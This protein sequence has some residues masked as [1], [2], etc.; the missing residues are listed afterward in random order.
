LDGKEKAGAVG[1]G[2]V[3]AARFGGCGVE[4]MDDVGMDL[5]QRNEF[6]VR[7]AEGGLETAAVFEDAFLA[8]PFGKTEIENFFAVQKA[9]AAGARAEAVDEPRELCERG[10]LQDLDAADFA[11]DPVR[12]GLGGRDSQECLSDRGLK[13]FRG[14][15][16]SNSIIGVG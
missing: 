1:D 5:F 3:S 12:V 15:H 16:N 13:C 7:C 10:D 11:F 6:E 4:K 2:G 8:I 9:D 14:S